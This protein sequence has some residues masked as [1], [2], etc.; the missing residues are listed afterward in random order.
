MLKKK[1]LKNSPVD[2]LFPYGTC[3]KTLSII[4]LS[5]HQNILDV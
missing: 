3:E 2:K 5:E 4:F 1:K